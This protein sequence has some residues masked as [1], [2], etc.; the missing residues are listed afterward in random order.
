MDNGRYRMYRRRI[1]QTGAQG[2][3]TAVGK[4]VSQRKEV[5]KHNEASTWVRSIVQSGILLAQSKMEKSDYFVQSV[6]SDG[7]MLVDPRH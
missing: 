7:T 6:E 5:S 3:G 4:A 1:G 2:S